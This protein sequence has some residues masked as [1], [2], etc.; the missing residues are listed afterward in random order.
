MSLRMIAEEKVG[1]FFG[2]PESPCLVARPVHA[3][4]FSVTRLQCRLDGRASRLVR[5]PAD[6]AYFLMLYLDD[7][8]HRDVAGDGTECE[9]RRY[10]EGSVCLVDLTHGASIRLVSDLDSLAFYMPRDLF[11]EVSK[12][13]NA[14]RATGLRCRRGEDDDVM[15]NLGTALLPFFDEQGRGQNAVLQHI[16]IAVCAHLLHSYTDPGEARGGVAGLSVWQ[17]KAAKD[18]MIEHFAEDFSFAAAAAAAGLS[19]RDFING[20]S[21]VAGL[22]PSQWLMRHRIVR[23]KQYLTSPALTLSEVAKRCGFSD[24]DQFDRAFRRATGTSPSDWRGRWLN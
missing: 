4:K 8:L 24:V 11:R 13:A 18:F 19:K 9:V 17:E 7:A 2:E 21:D 16:A 12:V 15:R 22:T 3:A 10:R 5:L 20:F 1:V 14:P 6:D 23:A